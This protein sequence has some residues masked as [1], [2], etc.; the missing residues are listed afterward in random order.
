[1]GLNLSRRQLIVSTG[2]LAALGL[3]GLTGCGDNGVQGKTLYSVSFYEGGYLG[4]EQAEAYT[5]A[6]HDADGWHITGT[7]QMSGTWM[8]DGDYIV[9][10]SSK[11]AR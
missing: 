8:Q 6:I 1:M 7:T 4:V 2:S 5:I 11:G 9:L 3:M 10:T